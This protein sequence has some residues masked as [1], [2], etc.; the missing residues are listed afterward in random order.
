MTRGEEI[1]M[2]EW[3]SSIKDGNQKPHIPNVLYDGDTVCDNRGL[4][5][6]NSGA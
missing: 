2:R 5:D 6:G 3:Q 4:R 1:F